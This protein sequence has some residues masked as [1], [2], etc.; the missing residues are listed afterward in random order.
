MFQFCDNKRCF[1]ALMLKILA[2]LFPSQQLLLLLL[3][4]G[5]VGAL[6]QDSNRSL[7][8]LHHAQENQF[9]LNVSCDQ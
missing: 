6:S 5:N 8:L 3:M 2:A 7:R 4:E 1:L 9:L